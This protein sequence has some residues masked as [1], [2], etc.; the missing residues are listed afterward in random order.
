M[1]STR[2]FTGSESHVFQ[3]RLALQSVDVGKS[4]SCTPQQIIKALDS[5]GALEIPIDEMPSLRNKIHPLFLSPHWNKF[6]NEGWFNFKLVLQL[7]TRLLTSDWAFETF[8]LHLIRPALERDIIDHMSD[9]KPKRDIS[10]GSGFKGYNIAVQ[11]QWSNEKLHDRYLK[12]I[13]ELSTKLHFG[14]ASYDYDQSTS[15]TRLVTIKGF[16]G[17][18]V[19]K[20]T[21]LKSAFKSAFVVQ[22]YNSYYPTPA[23]EAA[24]Q[25]HR[26][27]A[28]KNSSNPS[29]LNVGLVTFRRTIES[30]NI[31]LP[32]DTWQ[33]SYGLSALPRAH[34]LRLQFTIAVAIVSEVAEA[35]AKFLALPKEHIA[36]IAPEGFNDCLATCPGVAFQRKILGGMIIEQP[37]KPLSWWG[38][39][40]VEEMVEEL[41][42]DGWAEDASA[43][44]ILDK[45]VYTAT[46]VKGVSFGEKD[47]K[48]GLVGPA[49]GMI[50]IR[51]KWIC[52]L[53]DEET[54]E[55][56]EW[57]KKKF[58]DG[59]IENGWEFWKL[60]NEGKHGVKGF[61]I[62]PLPNNQL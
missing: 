43:G 6:E 48:K 32:K 61:T 42:P 25:P 20:Q 38:G 56:V 13:D 11:P 23:I 28:L 31:L 12:Y 53:F 51:S 18:L 34:R 60:R 19:P 47:K 5:Y 50:L 30:F 36:S 35:F 3:Q 10:A 29:K 54:W 27:A 24:F 4:Q 37:F 58:L 62:F 7:A 44:L 26:V 52:Q 39:P 2:V 1:S 33:R 55:M 22:P 46:G 41:L 8:W 14:F 57:G 16:G 49:R 15:F 59:Q 45:G 17:A 40:M 21:D 9:P